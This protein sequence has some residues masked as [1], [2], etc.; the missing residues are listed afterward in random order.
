MRDLDRSPPQASRDLGE[1]RARPPPVSNFT[2]AGYMATVEKAKDYIRAGDIFQVVPASAG[3]QTFALPPFA[4]YR[5]LRR[6]NPSPFMFYFNFGGFQVIG[7]SPEILVRVLGRRG[8]DP[9]DRRHPAA[10]R[11]R[12]TRTARSRPSCWPTRRSGPST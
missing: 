10:R 2:T 1:P 12:P 3:P 11:A 5:A 4:L 9:P 6:T 7:A 8:H